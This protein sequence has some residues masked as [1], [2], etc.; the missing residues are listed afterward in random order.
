VEALGASGVSFSIDTSK[1]EVARRALAGGAVFVNDVTALRGDPAM[2]EAVAS[3]GAEVC[4][5]H[6]LGEPQTMQ[7]N[8]RYDDVVSEVKS[9]LEQ[10][11][12]F[13]VDQGI[14]E[15]R[16]WMEPGIGFWQSPDHHRDQGKDSIVAVVEGEHEVHDQQR[17][18]LTADA[19]E[20]P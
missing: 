11:V 20:R 5:M 6:M 8:P 14:R 10:R 13:A 3:A 17:G 16:N 2:A 12:R 1:A 7:E 19:C 15:Q 18:H 9:F 4:L